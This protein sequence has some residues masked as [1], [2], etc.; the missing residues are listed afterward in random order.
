MLSLVTSEVQSRHSL[1]NQHL[2]QLTHPYITPAVFLFFITFSSPSHLLI[3]FS[4]PSHILFITIS[5][6][7]PSYLLLITFSL[8]RPPLSPIPPTSRVR[9]ERHVHSARTG[10]PLGNRRQVTISRSTIPRVIA[11]EGMERA[12]DTKR[13]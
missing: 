11:N 7:S 9:H 1:T 2:H 3:V 8:S 5:F 12:S 13:A 4:S 10:S 6:S